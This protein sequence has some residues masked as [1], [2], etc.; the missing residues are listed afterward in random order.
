MQFQ[1]NVSA[2]WRAFSCSAVGTVQLIMK[3]CDERPI[4]EFQL[5]FVWSTGCSLVNNDGCDARD[6]VCATRSSIVSQGPASRTT[7]KMAVGGHLLVPPNPHWK[8]LYNTS[9]LL[10]L[11][12]PLPP[13]P[14]PPPVPR[15]GISRENNC[16]S[17]CSFVSQ[18]K[19]KVS[20]N[21]GPTRR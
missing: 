3:E 12:T 4:V 20:E 1:S 8:T 16:A 6:G 19:R 17:S 21:G 9:N 15:S 10:L 11:L 7:P 13:P 5:S 2:H 18:T 14:P